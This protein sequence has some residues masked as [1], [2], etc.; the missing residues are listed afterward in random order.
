MSTFESV[1]TSECL[2]MFKF[3]VPFILGPFTATITLQI[4]IVIILI[5]FFI[6]LTNYK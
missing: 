2:D 5:I 1:D 6:R 3:N 4:T